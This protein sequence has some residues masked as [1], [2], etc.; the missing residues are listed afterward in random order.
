MMHMHVDLKHL[1]QHDCKISNL[2]YYKQNDDQEIAERNKFSHRSVFN[3]I[4]RVS[5]QD[6][7]Q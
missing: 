3:A 6:Y 4:Q 2:A 5:R 7:G 1:F